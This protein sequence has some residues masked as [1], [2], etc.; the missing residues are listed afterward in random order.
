M[1]TLQ[2]VLFLII[3]LIMLVHL[4]QH[5]RNKEHFNTVTVLRGKYIMLGYL[6][7]MEN[8]TPDVANDAWRLFGRDVVTIKKNGIR[9][10][11]TRHV[12]FYIESINVNYNIR[13]YLK[14]EH[15]K[16]YENLISIK[17][18]P[19]K[20]E[21]DHPQLSNS[22]YDVVDVYQFD[23]VKNIQALEQRLQNVGKVSIP[24]L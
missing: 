3:M 18:L 22:P 24:Q 8:D 20:L 23:F 19:N 12:Q 9:I 5:Q 16:N 15:I 10:T 6:F 13:I 4:Y 14:K 1:R 11:R 7:N 17:R 2:A 21:F